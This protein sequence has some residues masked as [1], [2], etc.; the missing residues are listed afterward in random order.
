[1]RSSK[2]RVAIADDNR[3]FCQIMIEYLSEQEEIEIIGVAND[4]M[5]AV[6]LVNQKKPDL[7]LLDIIMPYLD[8]FGVIKRLKAS[9]RDYEPKIIVVSNVGQENIA[10]KAIQLGAEYYMVKPFCADMLRERI[11]Q[12]A[13]A[14]LKPGRQYLQHDCIS[15]LQEQCAGSIENEITNILHDIGMPPHIKG[16]L[17][18]GEAIRL[19][20]HNVGLLSGITKELYPKIAITYGTTPSRVERAIRHAI[21]VSWNKRDLETVEQLFGVKSNMKRSKPTNSEFIATVAEKLRRGI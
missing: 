11:I 7:L 13:K 1:M 16:Y 4:G 21:E 6:E 2:V 15:A 9:C 8:G 14:E 3:E 12:I 10:Q 18:L 19:V 17:Y 5:E 20:V